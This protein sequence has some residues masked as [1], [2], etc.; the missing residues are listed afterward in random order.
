M[1]VFRKCGCCKITVIVILQQ[2]F[3]VKPHVEKNAVRQ[4]IDLVGYLFRLVKENFISPC[5]F[6]S[7]SFPL[8]TAFILWLRFRGTSLID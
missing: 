3:Y 7:R 4:H 5:C 6:R 2:F 8:S 1:L